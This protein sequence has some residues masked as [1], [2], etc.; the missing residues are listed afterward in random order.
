MGASLSFG[1]MLELALWGFGRTWAFASR[2]PKTQF[3]RGGA[4]HM[5]ELASKGFLWG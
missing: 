3:L 2:L 5:L 1:R 4:A